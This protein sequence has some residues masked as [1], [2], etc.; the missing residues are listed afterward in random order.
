MPKLSLAVA[1]EAI[2]TE[3]KRIE[4]NCLFTSKGHF[5]A[6]QFWAKFHL[7]IGFPTVILA[8][9][10]GTAA[11][12]KFDKDNIWA[13]VLSIIVVILT[14]VTTFLNPKEKAN[15]YLTAGN[16]YDSLLARTRMFWLID[17]RMENS[18][19][20]L[21]SRLKDLSEQRERL[22]R[23]CPQVPKG[24]YEKAKKGIE[25]GEADYKI[26]IV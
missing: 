20:I 10:A 2:I 14:S 22:N 23:D 3:A 24:T 7:W 5:Y 9:V 18:D 8:A 26:D 19:E 21:T 4:E 17:C 12:A 15:A 13:G 25:Q 1:K 16:N 11:L 6:A